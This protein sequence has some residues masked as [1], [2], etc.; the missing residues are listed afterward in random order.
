MFEPAE[1]LV[2][3]EIDGILDYG[4]GWGPPPAAILRH[5]LVALV[6]VPRHDID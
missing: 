4:L 3:R 6:V 1:E 5:W 2:I